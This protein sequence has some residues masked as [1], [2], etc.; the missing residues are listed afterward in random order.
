MG[1]T[2]QNTLCILFSD[3]LYLISENRVNAMLAANLRHLRF[4]V[5][6]CCQTT[7]CNYC[8]PVLGLLFSDT[9][10]YDSNYKQSASKSKTNLGALVSEL[11]ACE[12]HVMDA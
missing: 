7:N 3:T 12:D 5:K 9:A 8:L 1:P 4:L 6:C 10:Y 11:L 2:K